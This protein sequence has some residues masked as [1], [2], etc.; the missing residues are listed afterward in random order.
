[1]TNTSLNPI[2]IVKSGIPVRL[3]T[4]AYNIST[5]SGISGRMAP[6]RG[7]SAVVPG[8][9]GSIYRSGKKRDEGSIILSMWAQD[10]DVDGARPVSNRYRTWRNNM[11][12]L[13]TLFDTTL[14]QIEVQEYIDDVALGAVLPTTGYRRAI[15]EV[16]S[17]IDPDVLGK[18]FGKF[19]VEL[20]I[21]NTYWEDPNLITW[22]SPLGVGSVATHDLSVF[23][24]MTAPIEDGL[25]TVSGPITN[26]IVADTLS[27]HRVKLNGAVPQG[28]DWVVDSAN[29][30]SML[31]GSSVTAITVSEGIYTPRLFALSPNPTAP[32]QLQLLGSGT[33]TNTRVTYQARRKYH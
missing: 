14:G 22:Q 21:N 13:L 15:C 2:V 29:F 12:I 3:D 33:N 7:P 11:D 31:G 23:Q 16:R 4:L 9:T 17:A 26:P 32:P 19:S 6:T 30:T 10:A 25:L 5:K 1:M 18:T 27:G 28:Q 8:R 20:I 24:S